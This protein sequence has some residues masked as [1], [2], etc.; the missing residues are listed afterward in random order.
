M[1]DNLPFVIPSKQSNKGTKGGGKGYKYFGDPDKFEVHKQQ[2]VK[3]IKKITEDIKSEKPKIN[4]PEQLSFL[5][6]ILDPKAT[7]NSSVPVELFDEYG[8]DVN[9]R[10]ET[11]EI[12]ISGTNAAIEKFQTAMSDFEYIPQDN[13][14]GNFK[15]KAAALL[16]SIEKISKV[17]SEKKLD[18]NIEA[19]NVG[20]AYFYN[21]ISER[22][23][24]KISDELMKNTSI[25][26]EYM[27]S[28][29][30]AKILAG[31]FSSSDVKLIIN[32][33]YE[34]PF[35]KFEVMHHIG[36]VT[37]N[38]NVSY[39]MAEV[40]LED[41]SGDV[42]VGVVDGGITDL[43]VLSD[44]IIDRKDYTSDPDSDKHHGTL[45]A[46]RVIFGYDIEEQLFDRN[47]LVA[48]AKVV[49]IK[50]MEGDDGPLPY[51][52]IENL[53]DAIKSFP[54]IKIFSMSIGHAICEPNKK[55]YL[56]RELD[57][58]Q[59]KYNVTFV[60]SAGNRNDFMNYKYPDVL[61]DNLNTITSPADTA[62]GFSVGSLA[63]K[64]NKDSL[65]LI[66]EPSPFT[67]TGFDT[68]RKPD[69]VHYGGNA[70][71]TGIWRDQGVKGLDVLN[72]ELYENVGT[73][74]ATPVV[75]GE[76]AKAR[77][78][79]TESGYDNATDLTKALVIH[80][81]NYIPNEQSSIDPKVLDKIVGH[82]IPDVEKVLFSDPTKVVYVITDKI[83][84]LKEKSKT[85]REAVRK[86][87]FTIPDELKKLKRQ[88]NV[89]ATIAYTTPINSSDEVNVADSDVT[90]SL[91]KVNSAKRLVNSSNSDDSDYSYKPKWYTTK[92]L[93]RTY[94]HRSYDGGEWE[95][96]LTL[97]TRG[98]SADKSYEQPF[99][100]VISIED[101][102]DDEGRLNLQELIQN[103]HKQYVRINQIKNPQR[104][105]TS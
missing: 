96:W 11:N 38:V 14:D 37:N 59:H 54:F 39:P 67:R 89:R 46:S 87:K 68:F 93:E 17:S 65:A 29:S 35:A 60:V 80:S 99:A 40:D 84:G 32:D 52:L 70:R 83:G 10:L 105:T 44:L 100:L 92:C 23:A 95:L 24:K 82:G 103:N 51:E 88:L 98:D 71:A 86:V 81:A 85:T 34:N 50:V 16:S 77:K 64:A 53:E 75:S 91:H 49:D 25:K 36:V 30:G 41:Q 62:N 47:K 61:V 76:L 72:D 56:T 26:A 66:D 8:L 58:L 18:G 27:V 55:S 3:D 90:M 78:M 57:A 20:V 102:G 5:D 31:Q 48:R 74:F 42:V 97:Q 7:A 19:E 12:V 73:S 21:S 43:D 13:D 101:I 79:V 22:N 9:K 104:V 63:D 1:N 45:A 2:R 6:V 4:N 69:L 94:T 15:N 33:D 28:P